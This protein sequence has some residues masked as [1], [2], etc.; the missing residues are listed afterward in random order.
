[1]NKNTVTELMLQSMYQDD[2]ATRFDEMIS[3]QTYLLV[4]EMK[5]E[6][7]RVA[8]LRL[9]EA[10]AKKRAKDTAD[11]VQR[12]EAEKGTGTRGFRAAIERY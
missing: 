8:N 11:M 6:P 7:L 3:E 12:Q 10:V 2:M 5:L 1:M 9:G 4:S